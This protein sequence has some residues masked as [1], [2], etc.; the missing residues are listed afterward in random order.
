MF[1]I[2]EFVA[3]CQE[4]LAE[5]Q[6]ALA[7]KDVVERA[8]ADPSAIDDT[9]GTANA[10]GIR[11][12]HSSP[13]L[14]VLQFVWPPHVV[15][16]PHDHRMWA[17]N[18]IYA[19]TEDNTFFRR[20]AGGGLDESGGTQLEAG[21]VALLGS[22]V[23]HSVAN[24]RSSHTAAI[25]VYGGDFFGTPRSQWD[26]STGEE[27]PFDVENVRRVLSDADAAAR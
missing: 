4:A 13:E 7:V 27:A 24:P 10:G 12:L 17:A 9:L 20:R 3:S 1:D 26:R 21:H 15:L 14:T 5:V 16:F 8:V 18:G 22:E 11:T 2:D 6:P 25:H 23:I 19:G